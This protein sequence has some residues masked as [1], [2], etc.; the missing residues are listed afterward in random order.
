MI[1][2]FPKKEFAPFKEHLSYAHIRKVPW[3]VLVMI[4]ETP[5][6]IYFGTNKLEEFCAFQK[7]RVIAAARGSHKRN[8]N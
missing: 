8:V 4:Q 2:S 5:G 7:E 6:L 1:Y 3:L